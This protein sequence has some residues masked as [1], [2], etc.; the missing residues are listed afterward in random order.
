MAY[1]GSVYRA[2]SYS[3]RLIGFHKLPKSYKIY[4]NFNNGVFVNGWFGRIVGFFIGWALAGP[5]G[6]LFGVLLGNLIDRKHL[7][8]HYYS[9]AEHKYIQ[10]TYF[11]AT[12]QVMGHVAKSDGRVTENEIRAARTVMDRMRLTK[13]QRQ[14]AISYFRAGK[15]ASFN[16]DRTLDELLRSCQRQKILLQMFAEIQFNAA[17]ADGLDSA[18]KRQVLEIIC[19]RLGYRPRFHHQN[20]NYYQQ[21]NTH[22]SRQQSS[23]P[24]DYQLL[25]IPVSASNSDIKRA[26]RRQMSRNHPDKLIAQGLPEEMIKIAT[27]KTQKISAA[28]ERIRQARGF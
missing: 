11:R 4:N 19:Q 13:A 2:S 26:Y 24:L 8:R 25:E 18:K 14:R 7:R 20:Q 10:E 16:L 23:T 22:Q 6:A 9:Q 27:N 28:Y 17:K 12:F 1:S 15:A 21:Q 5:A 3:T